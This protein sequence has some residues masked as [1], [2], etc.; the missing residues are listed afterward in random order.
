MDFD[1]LL[2]S[3][4]QFA[5]TISFHI[6]FPSISIGLA[7]FLALL[8]GLW[9][10]TSDQRYRRLYEFWVKLFAIAFALGVVSGV[11]MSYQFGTNWSRFAEATGNVLGPLLG[12]EVLSAFFLEASFL[13]IMLFGWRLVGPGLHFVA[14]CVVAVGTLISAFWILSANSWMH[15]PAG[16]ELRD[17]IFYATD[18]LEI[19]FNPS[20]PYRLAHMVLAAY[21]TTAFLIAGT[22]A[23]LLIRRRAQSDAVMM[24][25]MSLGLAAIL[26]PLQIFAGHEHGLSVY[27]M[28][29][30]KH[31]AIEGHWQSYEGHAPLILFAWPDQETETNLHEFSIPEIGSLL[32]TGSADGTVFGL[33]EWPREDRPNVAIVFWSFRIMVGIGIIM[34]LLAPLGAWA[35]WRGWMARSRILLWPFVLMAPSGIVAVLAGWITAEAGR[36][37]FTVYGLMRTSESVSPVATE[38]V[39]TSLGLFVFV[40]LIVFTAGTY[41]MAKIA[42]AGP[43]GAPVDAVAIDP[44]NTSEDEPSMDD[45]SDEELERLTAPDDEDSEPDDNDGDDAPEPRLTQIGRPFEP[46]FRAPLSAHDRL[47]MKDAEEDEED[48]DVD[49]DDV[50]HHDI[51]EN[52]FVEEEEGVMDDDFSDDEVDDETD[53]D[54]ADM[55]DEEPEEKKNGNT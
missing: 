11:A 4:L 25:K 28:Q 49:E 47:F 39:A 1:A 46:P 51:E 14:T 41:Y 3:R 40:Y 24:L 37:P 38:Q 2:L 44:P 22:A 33:L 9:L 16:F 50:E 5:F 42:A 26:V 12:Y 7:S 18:W 32:A 13:G 35:A 20:F 21:I 10:R 48:D 27:R 17:G 31:A 15:T 55:E 54:S 8:E 23:W 43:P 19:I 45:L 34:L 53:A 29:P 6:I 30:A 52:E 36:Q